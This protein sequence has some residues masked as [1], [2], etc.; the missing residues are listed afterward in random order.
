MNS[1]GVLN[2]TIGVDEKRFSGK[3]DISEEFVQNAVKRNKEMGKCKRRGKR[4]REKKNEK[5]RR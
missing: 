1:M 5:Q 2:N 4:Y 3:E